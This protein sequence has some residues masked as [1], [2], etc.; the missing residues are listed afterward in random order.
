MKGGI[1]SDE[2][3]PVCNSKFR[4]LGNA[5]CCPQHPKCRASRLFVKFN[6]VLRRFRSYNDAFRFLTGLRFKTDEHTFD[7]RDYKRDNPLGFSNMSSKWLSYKRDE[8]RKGTY[9]NLVSHMRYAQGYFNNT[10]VKEIGFGHLEDFIKS[11]KLSDKSRH[12]IMFTIHAFFLWMKRRQEISILPEFPVVLFELGYRKT[13]DKETQ[14]RI[15]EEIGRICANEKVYLGIK[16]LATYIS[17]RPGE[18]IKLTEGNIDTANGYLYIPA[19]DSKTEYKS[20]P[21]IPDDINTLKTF[22]LSPFPEMPF[23]RHGSGISGVSENAPFGE[24]YFY[25]WWVKACD[26]LGIKGVDLYGG[27]RH[28]SV[29]ALRKYRSPEEIKRAAMSET[30]K[31]FERYM[32]KDTDDD[33]RS[34]YRQ[35]A[36]VISIDTPADTDTALILPKTS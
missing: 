32:G 4:D 7:E 25:K 28:S 17:V 29:R 11:I 6:K 18:L 8:V 36:E 1:Y 21:L 27:T 24:K 23:F 9:K 34:V 3:C 35:S 19:S 31:A 33:L 14:Q 20:I 10:N 12:N 30:N 22:A 16:W 26:N 5:L 2:R 15:I 13:V